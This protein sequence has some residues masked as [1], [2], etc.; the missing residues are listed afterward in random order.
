V[1]MVVAY[2]CDVRSAREDAL[3]LLACAD[4]LIE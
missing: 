1:D 3:M 2:H 4:E